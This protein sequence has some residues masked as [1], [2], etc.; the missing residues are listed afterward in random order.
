MDQTE[1]DSFYLEISSLQDGM[2]F[3]GCGP[4]IGLI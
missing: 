2:G 4:V 1:E 3:Y